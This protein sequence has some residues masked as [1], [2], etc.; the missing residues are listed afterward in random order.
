MTLFKYLKQ[1]KVPLLLLIIF[2]GIRAGSELQLPSYTSNIVDIG[3]QQDGIEDSVATQL[4]D[5]TYQL[6]Q[7][8]MSEDDKKLM[9][10]AYKKEQNSYHLKNIDK[11]QHDQLNTLLSNSMLMLN[12]AKKEHLNLNQLKQGIQAGVVTPKMLEENKQKILNKLGTQ[13]DFIVQQNGILFVKDEYKKLGISIDDL[14][15]AYLKSMAMKMILFTLLSGGASI[16]TNY[17]ASRIAATVGRNLRQQMYEKVLTFSKNEIEKFSMASLITRSTNDIQQIQTTLAISLF[18]V[19]FSPIMAIWGIYKVLQ[20]NTSMTWIIALGVSILIATVGSL[21]AISIPKFK[22]MQK[23]IDNV[24]L[25]SREIL[26]GL[27]VIRVF[28][29]EKYEEERFSKVS[30]SLMSTQLFANR[31]MVFLMPSIMLIMNGL[32]VLII[33]IGGHHIDKGTIQV[34]DMM[35]FLTYTMQIVMSFLMLTMLSTMLPRATVAA[36]R[37]NEVLNT[38]LTI[39]DSME[40]QDDLLNDVKGIIRFDNV[41]ITFSEAESPI[42]KNISFQANPGE[43][44]AII[45]STGSGKSTLINLIPR[46][47]D[48]TEGRITIDGVDIRQVSLEKL[49]S[50]QGLVPQKGVLFSGNIADN[51]KFGNDQMSQDEMLFAAEV[52]QA[53]DFINSKEEGFNSAIAQGGSNVSGG[54]KQRLSIARAIARRPKILLFDDSFSALDNKT[55]VKLRNSL[56]QH[57]KDATTIIV[58]QRISTILH[59]DNIIV[60]NNGEIVGQGQH[61]ELLANCKT[62]QQ[63]AESQ[64]SAEELLKGGQRHV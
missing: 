53:L 14:R 5:E 55:E 1:F 45:G 34:G 35:A 12:G 7:L 28:G 13:S 25:V 31:T 29:R 64:L 38:E 19:F 50:I 23:L 56:R 46:F 24:N 49:R 15:H 8:F 44:T 17:F 6:L 9:D 27:S 57:M 37:V 62:Y 41:S 20:T 63:I 51:I 54:Q 18:I 32:G 40:T 11:A 47:F 58:A 30:Q 42:L 10:E 22:M 4:T 60:L 36:N 33:W 39:V 3:I 61:Q 59:A 43:T 16:V 52:S 21:V 48:V 26:T 2:L